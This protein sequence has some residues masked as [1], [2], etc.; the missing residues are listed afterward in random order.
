MKKTKFSFKK[1]G[2]SIKNGAVSTATGV[3]ATTHLTALYVRNGTEKLEA[4]L[5]KRAYGEDPEE[6][7]EDRRHHSYYLVHKRKMQYDDAKKALSKWTNDIRQEMHDV[8]HQ[9]DSLNTEEK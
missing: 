1:V 5:K 6:V 7:M 9:T 2:E 3:L 4:A 8:L